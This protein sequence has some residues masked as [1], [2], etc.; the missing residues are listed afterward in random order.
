MNYCNNISVY[1]SIDEAKKAKILS[2]ERSS[3]QPCPPS[4][5]SP[6]TSKDTSCEEFGYMLGVI[7]ICLDICVSWIL[8]KEESTQPTQ[9][10][11]SKGKVQV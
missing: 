3:P 11:S 8:T 7:Y 5:N 6:A 1:S 4:T 9:S 2:K 10:C